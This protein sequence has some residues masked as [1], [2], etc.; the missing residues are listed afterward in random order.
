[1]PIKN[2]DKPIL[3]IM[4]DNEPLF[5][6]DPETKVRS[7]VTFKKVALNS[8]LNLSAEDQHMQGDEK[9]K[10]FSIA[11]LLIKGGDVELKADELAKIKE[12][13]RKAFS[14]LITGQMDALLDE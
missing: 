3:N 4:K 7:E 13:V 8:L 6:I 14:P 10:L 12:R 11:M 9:A 5:E 2:F 1:M